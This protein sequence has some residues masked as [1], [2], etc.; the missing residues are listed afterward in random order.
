MT[1][2]QLTLQRQLWLDFD[3]SGFSF[4]DA[5]RG[6]MRSGWRLDM[7]DPYSL[8]SA[9]EDNQALLITNGEGAGQTG[10]ELRSNAL[11]LT[12]QGRSETR[13]SMPVAGWQSRF[14]GQTEYLRNGHEGSVLYCWSR[15]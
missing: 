3:G 9:S 5:V 6:T 15:H 13:G 11:S 14:D 1:D 7:A 12:A 2:N 8:L 10:V 4:V